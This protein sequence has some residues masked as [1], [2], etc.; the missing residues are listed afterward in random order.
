MTSDVMTLTTQKLHFRVSISSFVPRSKN[1]RSPRWVK[2]VFQM[3]L[4]LF[5]QTTTNNAVVVVSVVSHTMNEIA[6]ENCFLND[7]RRSEARFAWLNFILE[8]R[9]CREAEGKSLYQRKDYIINRRQSFTRKRPS[10]A[11]KKNS[12][13]IHLQKKLARYANVGFGPYTETKGMDGDVFRLFPDVV[14]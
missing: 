5:L 9:L 4:S 1:K 3:S 14:S 2:I 11:R 13:T 6:K 12:L 10:S 8:C 7:S